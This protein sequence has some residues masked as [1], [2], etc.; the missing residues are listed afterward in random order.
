MKNKNY[1]ET[2]L[3][4][5]SLMLA[6]YNHNMEIYDSHS[7][8]YKFI[9]DLQ[10]PKHPGYHSYYI[11]RGGYLAIELGFLNRPILKCNDG[12]GHGYKLDVLTGE[13]SPCLGSRGTKVSETC[14]ALMQEYAKDIKEIFEPYINNIK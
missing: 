6:M 10:E 9:H 13:K 3:R 14:E 11:I 2:L 5:W 8:F 12:Y 1:V 7:A 4:D